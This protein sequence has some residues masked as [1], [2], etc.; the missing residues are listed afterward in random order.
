MFWKQFVQKMVKYFPDISRKK[1]WKT[2]AK[3]VNFAIILKVYGHN[4]ER[5]SNVFLRIDISRIYFLLKQTNPQ[6][7]F[8]KTKLPK[9]HFLNRFAQFFSFFTIFFSFFTI[10]LFFFFYVFLIYLWF[11]PSFSLI[12][13]CFFLIGLR[14]FS[15][16][17]W[18]SPI[19][20]PTAFPNEEEY[21]V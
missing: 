18:F 16:F 14:T 13:F 20:L 12:F 7:R 5:T 10:F 15:I 17:S 4:L 3:N 2:Y 21:C 1:F 6:R 8:P 9:G 11:F 19:F